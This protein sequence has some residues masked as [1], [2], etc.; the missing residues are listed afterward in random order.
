[1]EKASSDVQPVDQPLCGLPGLPDRLG[2]R[3]PPDRRGL[4][5]PHGL[6]DHHGLCDCWKVFLNDEENFQSR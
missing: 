3:G 1:M 5:D 2:L 4:H 6:P